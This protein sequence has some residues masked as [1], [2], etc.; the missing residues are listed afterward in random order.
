MEILTEWYSIAGFLVGMII[1]LMLLGLP[2]AFAFLTTNIIG[3]AIF[4]GDGT[5]T[6][7][8]DAMP[9]IVSNAVD[10][11]AIFALIPVPLFIIMGELFFHTGLAVRVFDAL[12]RCFGRL[13]GRLSYIT[14]AGGTIFATLSGSTMAN[15]AMM[16]SLM[17]P[18]M[19]KRG[20]KGHMSMGPILGT[21]G[22]AMIIPPSALAVLL[23]SLAEID[24]GGLLIAGVIP[25]LI[26][27]VLYSI[28]IYGQVKLDPEAAPEYSVEPSPLKEIIW[29][30]IVNVLP[31]GFIVFCVIGL[32]IL[33][34]ATPTEAAGFGALG[35]VILG[36]LFR[37]LTW[38]VIVKSF[39]GS[40]RVTAMVLLIILAS[41][42]FSQLLAF[43]G[44][45]AGLIE[46]ATEVKL[47]PLVILLIMFG[48]L[49]ILG[50]F[51]DQVSMML[52]TVP[53]FFPLAETLQFDLVWFGLIM[54]LALEI[55]LTTPPFGLLLFVMVAV[56][57]KGTTLWQVAKAA[58]PYIG[59]ALIV[60]VLLIIFPELALYLP[61]LMNS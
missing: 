37:V 59:C 3:A 25:G 45:S 31:M 4:M 18:E 32:I 14:V 23:A 15:T 58:A 10:S 21:G 54:L 7:G 19:T 34:V 5:L 48:V 49:L 16:G 20:Y 17:V 33:G 29:S 40:L 2:V 57:P 26:L 55:S 8:L 6:G 38:E 43:T 56:A 13:P 24:I 41:T 1:V 42:T 36:V 52:L 50:M 11:V 44:A 30:L 35:V 60:L 51:M 28:L 9:L 27:A 22:L 46:W 39:A 47:A 61:S 12:D 53:I